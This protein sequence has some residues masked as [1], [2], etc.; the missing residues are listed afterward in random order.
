MLVVLSLCCRYDKSVD[1]LAAYLTYLVSQNKVALDNNLYKR[2]AA[3]A[4]ASEN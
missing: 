4:V 3:P 2:P 1:Q